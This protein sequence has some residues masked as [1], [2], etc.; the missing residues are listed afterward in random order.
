MNILLVEDDPNILE[1]LRKGL[2]LSFP[3]FTVETA[4]SAEAA[5]RRVEEGFTPR[6]VIADVRLPGKSGVDL[7]LALER[8]LADVSFI[9]TSGYEP[10]ELPGQAAEERLLSFLP[11]PFE[12]S[13][14]VS[15]V[16]AAYLRDQFSGAHRSISFIDIL[17]VLNMARR[18]ALVEL[19]DG[20][21]TVG[22]IY[23]ASGEILHAEH[24]D[25]EHGDAE[26]ADAEGGAAFRALCARPGTAFRVRSGVRPP[27]RTI[28]Q[29]FDVLL[30]EV[31]SDGE[32]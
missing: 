16:Q 27:R 25:A 2:S 24:A 17:Q 12:L 22:G 10:P 3:T 28:E 1:T 20:D 8:R 14:L 29:P 7:L 26:H 15:E 31:M 18:T 13:R 5:E 11:K 23:V 6:L 30:L 32:E 9:L 19:F 21:R 4:G